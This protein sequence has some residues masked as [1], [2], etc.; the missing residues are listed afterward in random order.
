MT[1]DRPPPQDVDAE[2]AVLGAC[3]M[4]DPAA[5]DVARNILTPEAFYNV[6]HQIL[7]S[8]IYDVADNGEPVD[9]ITVA[10]FLKE[11][12][13]L[14]TVGGMFFLADLASDV[15]TSANV[16]YH[17]R[18]VK[19]AYVRRE[20]LS[21]AQTLANLCMDPSATLDAINATAGALL[22]DV[23]S[24]TS[25]VVWEPIQETITRTFDSIQEIRRT[26]TVGGIKTGLRELDA[27]LIALRP[28]NFVVV[29]GRPSIGKTA[30]GL[31]IAWNVARSMPVGFVSVEMSTAELNERL[32]AM[33]TGLDSHDLRTGQLAD[34]QWLE[35]T[36]S[37][38]K[39][40]VP[41][42]IAETIREPGRICREAK[43][44]LDEHGIGLLVIDYLQLLDA[45]KDDK[46]RATRRNRE[47]EVSAISRAIKGMAKDL[48]VPVVCMAQLNRE[49]ERR[50]G[51]RPALSDL[52]DSGSIE[53]DADVVLLLHR[54]AKYGEM[55]IDGQDVTR[56]L[57]VN[58]AKHRNGPTG[59][60]KLF[61]NE[62]TGRIGTWGGMYEWSDERPG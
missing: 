22:P 54:P 61:F 7:F 9:Q 30:L 20:V 34:G 10:D 53:Q 5:V 33:V 24:K 52:R 42:F 32:M 57:E 31:A 43:S 2:R 15:G 18:I 26:G 13:A 55:E 45:P 44:L 28:G 50:D 35:L 38:S 23:G 62:N 41:L 14:S 19:A 1:P 46:D 40:T 4:N 51:K 59:F 47:Q 49:S 25:E 58:I 27:A 21:R 17:A 56:L 6:G 60:L 16:E 39:F 29:A 11:R 3:L 48:Q 12:S 36:R 37:A 8:A